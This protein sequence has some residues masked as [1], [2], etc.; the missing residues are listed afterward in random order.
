MEVAGLIVTGGLAGWIASTLL[1][2]AGYG[3]VVNIVIGVV[4]GIVGGKLFALMGVVPNGW[5]VSLATAVVGALL[6]LSLLSLARG[7]R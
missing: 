7:S 2:G 5:L 4:G 6:L 1:R 3:L